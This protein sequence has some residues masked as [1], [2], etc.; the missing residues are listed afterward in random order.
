MEPA[1]PDATAAV[2]ASSVLSSSR[3]SSSSHPSNAKSDDS[4][5][6]AA[7]MAARAA[8]AAAQIQSMAF[9]STDN[10]SLMRPISLRSTKTARTN[11]SKR[12][13][14][15]AVPA[16][17]AAFKSN[18]KTETTVVIESTPAE[19]TDEDLADR[20]DENISTEKSALSQMTLQRQVL[21][22]S[23]MAMSVF[24][25]SLDQTIVAS[26]M[27]AIADEFDALPS[28]SW[29]ATG[30]L[31]ASTAMQ[32]LYGRLSDIFGRIET[33]MVGLVIFLV[34]SAV[35]GAATS[36]GMLIGGRVV[37]GLGASALVSLVMVIISD[38]TIERER[39]KITSIFSAIWAASSVLG[40]VL[41]GLF[42]ESRGGWPWV[43]YF[44]L[45]VGA[46]AGI[47]IA[48]FLRL[49]RPRGSF[50]DKL[51]R[52]DFAGMAV[53]VAGIVM[54][55]L[56][57]SFGGGA[58]A[59][60]SPTVLC[61]LIFGIA[62]VG[63]FVVIEWKIPA[64]PIMPLRLFRSRNVGLVLVMQLFVGAVMFGPTFYIPIYFSVVHNSSAIAAG[65]HLL[66]YILPITIFSTIAG[67]VVAKTGRYRELIWLGGSIATVG[68]GLFVLMDETT[69]TGKSI[70][71]ILC[72]GAG[73]G[74][75]LQPMLLA[76]QTAIQPRDM[77][78]GTTLFV[79]IRTL[80]GSI[81]LAV[82]QTVQQNKLA[83]L[84]AKLVSQYPQYKLLI[85]KA[86]DSPA[87]IRAADTPP[88]ITLAL[89]DAYVRALRAVFYASIPFAAMVV[90]LAIFVRHIPLR[91]RMTKT[92]ED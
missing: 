74:L 48:V 20:D 5:F 46:V 19:E 6:H 60:S 71:L 89:I 9:A 78:T 38:I 61:L 47:F 15:P 40:P 12:S 90:V 55:L 75:I 50:R 82:F 28:V 35:A 70:G 66:P 72:G 91:T 79:A 18:A 87:V 77:A 27:P 23:A 84:T 8:G 67:F 37:Q 53:L 80:G 24:I 85:E 17:P 59:W 42:T 52:V 4:E 44:S 22:L 64:E 68:A 33:L 81:G 29:I 88:E 45:P 2:K 63:A 76:L 14:V 43:F 32:P 11:A 34:G 86:V 41:G 21:T 83:T 25:G 16:I 1:P 3:S 92:V 57:L 62:T 65:L 69:T 58:Y 13:I 73:M 30:F 49:P 10:L 31:L 26:S 39:G 51:R 36:I 54:A 7:E 56:A